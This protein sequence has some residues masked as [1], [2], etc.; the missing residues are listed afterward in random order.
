MADLPDTSEGGDAGFPSVGDT[1]GSPGH[2]APQVAVPA[3]QES[4][5]RVTTNV[6][7]QIAH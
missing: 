1:D 2:D 7:D 6:L 5:R 4:P 3:T